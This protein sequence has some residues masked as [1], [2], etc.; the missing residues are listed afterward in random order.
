MAKADGTTFT[1]GEVSAYFRSRLPDLKQTGAEWRMPCPVHSG[2]RESFAVKAATGYAC[3]HSDCNK[4]WDIIGLEMEMFGTDFPTAKKEIFAVVGRADER[5]KKSFAGRIEKVYDYTDAGGGLL[6]QIVRLRD[7]KDFRQ[8]YP[9]GKGGWTWKKFPGQ[10]LYRLHQVID[11][12]VVFVTEGEKDADT[13]CS[14]GLIAT[15]N[16]GGADAPWLPEYT[17]ALSHCRCVV[18]FPDNDVPGRRRI[19]RVADALVDKVPVVVD[20]L[21]G[22]K[23]VTEWFIAGHS[24]AELTRE[25]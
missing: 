11:A 3:C 10:V 17:E 14:H 20:D 21:D 6:Y 16:A 24:A 25:I 12:P 22:A 2:T 13:L 5:V 19:T 23:D 7:P 1:R 18:L 8:R 4:G 15:T 9:D